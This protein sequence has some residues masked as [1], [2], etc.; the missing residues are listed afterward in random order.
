MNSGR[1][2]Q[3][4]LPF[5][6]SLFSV[7]LFPQKKIVLSGF[8]RISPDTWR[9]EFRT[10]PPEDL[11]AILEES[12]YFRDARICDTE[13]SRIVT[14]V[15]YPL[16]SSW[17][18]EGN[19]VHSREWL[20]DFFGFT[21]GG[22]YN[23]TILAGRVEE[24]V[25]MISAQG[26]SQFRIESIRI[27]DRGRVEMVVDEGNLYRIDVDPPVVSSRITGK[28]FGKSL[29]RPFCSP[30]IKRSLEELLYTE[31]FFSVHS[32]VR[33]EEDKVV[34]QVNPDLK[35]L[36]SLNW[37]FAYSRI[38]GFDLH[39]RFS[40]IRK[41]GKLE[42]FSP[43]FDLLLNSDLTFA[44]ISWEESDYRRNLGKSHFLWRGSVVYE[45]PRGNDLHLGGAEIFTAYRV[46]VTPG[47]FLRARLRTGWMSRYEEENSRFFIEPG[48]GVSM[49]RR[50]DLDRFR[51]FM[52]AEWAWNPSSANTRSYAGVHLYWKPGDWKAEA[53]G[54]L[55]NMHGNVGQT[56]EYRFLDEDRFW[57]PL[58]MLFRSRN[59]GMAGVELEMPRLWR[60][61]KPGFFVQYLKGAGEA[62]PVGVKLLIHLQRFPMALRFFLIR[63]IPHLQLCTSFSVD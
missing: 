61:L 58:S 3:F 33:R 35:R 23:R 1:R 31:A 63:N 26:F 14:V 45:H 15:E 59:L 50:G 60:L 9:E 28:I 20:A 38:G 34:L 22:E 29:N 53:A 8:E 49:E 42:F 39:S 10:L 51:I 37:K 62:V 4:L 48:I 43:G 19:S 6:L 56:R 47:I 57:L 21:R 36:H 27:D 16:I 46:P 7:L 13:E 24:Y 25:R 32:E 54:F 30:E 44:R 40:L 5:F 52:E 55:L 12:G 2:K 18:I 11:Q 17:T 41:N